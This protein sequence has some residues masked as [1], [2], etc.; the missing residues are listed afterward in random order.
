MKK[1]IIKYSPFMFPFELE[2]KWSIKK[3]KTEWGKINE[4]EYIMGYQMETTF[5]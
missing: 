4:N 3:M 1:K 2:E 5:E